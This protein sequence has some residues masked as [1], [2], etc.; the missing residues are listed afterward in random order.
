MVAH[1][2]SDGFENYF[3][4]REAQPVYHVSESGP[5]PFDLLF[6]HQTT[7]TSG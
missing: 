1:N 7:T 4:S 3:T 5:P 6:T 2:G